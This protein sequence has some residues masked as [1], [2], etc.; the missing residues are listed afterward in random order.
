[1][2]YILVPDIWEK[3]LVLLMGSLLF[4][5]F[6][7]LRYLLLLIAMTAFAFLGGW[8]IEKCRVGKRSGYKAVCLVATV[9]LLLMPLMYFKYAGFLMGQY[10]MFS[11]TPVA[12]PRFVLPMG[13]SF[14]T[15]KL[16]SYV[17][18][19]FMGHLDSQSF[20]D[21]LQYSVLFHQ[22]SEGPI[23]R[24]SDIKDALHDRNLDAEMF[25]D[26][27]M[28]FFIGLS[29]K[30]ILANHLGLLV[31]SFLPIHFLES[32]ISVKAAWLGSLFY[33]LQIY[34][35]FSAY[36]DMAIGLGMMC[37][38]TYPE[39]FNYP[40]IA[41]SVRDFWRRWHISLSSFF[42]DYVYIP[43]GGSRVHFFR[44]CVNLSVVWL[45]TG[46][47][48]GASWNYILWGAYYLVFIIFENVVLKFGGSP[49]TG[50]EDRLSENE[51]AVDRGFRRF[52]GHAY[53]LLVVYFGWILFRFT[54][55]PSLKNVFALL[56][57]RTGSPAS[58]EA[59][60]LL[61]KNNVYF[62]IV[63]IV[64]VTPLSRI[65]AQEIRKAITRKIS[66][67]NRVQRRE[68]RASEEVG[69]KR[70]MGDAEASDMSRKR[71]GKGSEQ[72]GEN[73]GIN[74]DRHSEVLDRVQKRVRTEARRAGMEEALYFAVKI[75]LALVL[76]ALSI[77][78][79]VG[80][81]YMPFLYD[82]F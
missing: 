17:A 43:M 35:D 7:G 32:S 71:A 72:A 26:G 45:L 6:A 76:F 36:S 40:Y 61:L 57:L 21:V 16:I 42:R 49:R 8:G 55:F 2:L 69:S 23:M 38:F 79:M 20:F 65:V 19:V 30:T 28:R 37:G 46:I 53:T 82:Q 48:H 81:S 54:D 58:D 29:K 33:M 25:T 13:I 27:L 47:W 24:F 68:E 75:A 80:S 62:L 59:T 10:G 12:M 15:F 52:F 74:G 41:S 31:E 44:L 18:D 63:C 34:L 5:A 77:M 70:G 78:S 39:N 9:I 67:K 73:A 11:E 60:E 51:G 22:V 50:A 1:M 64:A 56:F 66:L 14:Y 4:Y 3:N